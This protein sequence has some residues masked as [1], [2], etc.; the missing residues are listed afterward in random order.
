MKLILATILLSHS[1]WGYVYDTLLVDTHAT[2]APKLLM[3]SS[4]SKDIEHLSICIVC[5][6]TDDGVALRF[7]Q[8]LHHKYKNI[9]TVSSHYVK[10]QS[11]CSRSHMLFLFDAPD[12]IIAKSVKYAKLNHKLTMSYSSRY[13]DLGVLL[14]LHIG[15]SVKPYLNLSPSKE[16]GISFSNS[17]KRVSK[18]WKGG[19]I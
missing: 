2:L 9:K 8:T 13:L 6:N 10:M 3:M 18:L 17:L 1:L 12:E 14:S 11:E 19:W 4:V 7:K 16:Y 15:R 5:E